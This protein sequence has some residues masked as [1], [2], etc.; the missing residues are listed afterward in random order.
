MHYKPFYAEFPNIAAV[1]TRT[2][3]VP[4]G[5]QV[6]PMGQYGFLPSYCVD[7]KCDCRRA[8]INVHRPDMDSQAPP[9][10]IL[11]YGWEPRSFYRKWSPEMPEEM[12]NWFKGPAVEPMQS[13]GPYAEEL[14]QLFKTLLEDKE[15]ARR[16][17]RHYVL[18]KWKIGM[19]LPK[20]LQPWLGLF[21]DCPCGSGEKFKFCCGK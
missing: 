16:Y 4:A 2:V 13:Q 19:K 15:Y 8:M 10:A 18:F 6:L 14:L 1:Q 20:D 12:L 5:E 3:T 17:I 11:S 7:K 9:L 21:H